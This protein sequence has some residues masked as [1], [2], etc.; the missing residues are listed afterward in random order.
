MAVQCALQTY[1]FETFQGHN[2]RWKYKRKTTE[3]EDRY[4]ECIIKQ[5]DLLPL[6][7][8]TNIVSNKVLPVSKTMVR[9]RHSEAGLGS[10]IVTKK[11]GLHIENI[12]KRLE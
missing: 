5:N 8:I 10:Y 1:T 6:Q 7:D 4:I 12:I 2:A 11:P 3:Y 9:R